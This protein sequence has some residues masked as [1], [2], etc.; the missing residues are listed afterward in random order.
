VSVLVH[1]IGEFFPPTYEE[2]TSLLPFT[3]P[4]KIIGFLADAA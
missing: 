2:F 1:N 4:M 3:G